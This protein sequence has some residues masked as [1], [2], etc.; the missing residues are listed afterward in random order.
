MSSGTV[1]FA[2]VYLTKMEPH[3]L[4]KNIV[5]NNYDSRGQLGAGDMQKLAKRTSHVVAV[6][7]SP[8]EVEDK[9]KEAGGRDVYVAKAGDINL[10]GR[11]FKIDKRQ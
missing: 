2:E 1:H 8:S 10:S 7:M 5:H 6:Q 4:T 9:S 3:N 11:E